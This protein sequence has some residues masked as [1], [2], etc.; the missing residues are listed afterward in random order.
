MG[1]DDWED[2]IILEDEGPTTRPYVV[3]GGNTRPLSEVAI[4]MLVETVPAEAA[5]LRFEKEQV[6]QLA[7]TAPLSVAELSAHLKMP[8]GTTMVLVGELIGSG[9]LRSHETS[10]TSDL[11]DLN[12]MTRII[13]R[14]REL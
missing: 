14:V 13:N 6:A 4:E 11:S 12:I 5:G 7:A 1:R 9:T 8:I 10:T 3:T 2:E